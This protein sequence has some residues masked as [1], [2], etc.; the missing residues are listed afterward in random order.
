MP[1]S[2]IDCQPGSVWLF[3]KIETET[4]YSDE[5]YHTSLSKLSIQETGRNRHLLLGRPFVIANSKSEGFS[6]FSKTE[7]TI[8]HDDESVCVSISQFS[9]LETQNLP[10]LYCN[11]QEF[12]PSSRDPGEGG[13]GRSARTATNVHDILQLAALGSRNG[14]EGQTVGQGQLPDAV[15]KL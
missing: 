4:R 2:E 13:S 8:P 9:I 12:R 7:P 6:L 14:C 1:V 5:R 11:G 10:R 3:S 15:L